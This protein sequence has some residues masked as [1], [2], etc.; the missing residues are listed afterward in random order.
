MDHANTS[1]ARLRD[2]ET[3][4]DDLLECLQS[5]YVTE[6]FIE[7]VDI[8]TGTKSVR[9]SNRVV[10]SAAVDK[11]AGRATIVSVGDNLMKGAAGQA[12]QNMNITCGFE[13][14]LGLPIT[15]LYP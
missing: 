14:P 15:G 6:P 3:S 2:R 7:V 11:N 9:G 10:I 12:I 8:P 5:A 1:S 4:T 13:E